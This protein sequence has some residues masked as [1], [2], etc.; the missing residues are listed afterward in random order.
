MN[1]SRSPSL[2]SACTAYLPLAWIFFRFIFSAL[3]TSAEADQYI[4]GAIILAAAPCTA[5]V[6]VWSN[7]VDGEPHFTLS[8]VALNDGIMI[9][10]NGS[11]SIDHQ[12]YNFQF[13]GQMFYEVKKGKVGRALRDV[14]YQSNSI[15][16]WNA[17]DMIGSEAHWELY[18][19][20]YDGKG[21]PGQSNAVS[22]GCP[23]ARFKKI[24]ILNVNAR[25]KA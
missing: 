20:F 3:M 4:A 16:F 15:E 9:V 25:G 2:I 8:Q 21:E 6:F 10:G 14:A 13:S 18:G 12:R 22:H 23:P 7:L 1:R 24:D 11:W 17:C 5:M 19:S